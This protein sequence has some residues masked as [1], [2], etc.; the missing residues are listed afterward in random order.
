MATPTR[1]PLWSLLGLLY[2]SHPWHGIDAGPDFPRVVTAFIE[3]V[4]SD[5]VKYEVDK[6]SGHLMIDRPQ[7]YSCVLPCLYGFIPRTLCAER[8]AALAGAATGGR[9]LNGDDDPIDVC[10]LT[11]NQIA[12]GDILAQAIPIGGFRMIDKGEADDKIIAV[13]KGDATYGRWRDI[14][15]VPDAVI[16]KLKHY[17][18]AYKRGP[19]DECSSCE[20]AE[21]YGATEA[22]KVI[23]A[24]H[25]D[26]LTRFPDIEGLLSAALHG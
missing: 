23:V 7:S 16:T 8:V 13:L 17:F 12:R 4:P 18:V 20:I 1:E 3:I 11:E 15:D 2:K 14:G 21:V 5:T 22:L 24:S 6:I 9:A 25:D 19:D 10:V 26:Y